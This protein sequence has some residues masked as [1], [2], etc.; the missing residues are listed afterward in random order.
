MNPE[1]AELSARCAAL[2]CSGLCLLTPAEEGAGAGARCACPE[3]WVLA[4]DGRSCAPNCTSAHF[5]CAAALKCIPFWWR[6]DTQDDCGDGSDEPA[7]CPP[8]RCEPGQF[9]CDSGRCVH[10]SH[11]CDG[12]PHCADGSDERDCDKFTCLASQWKCR[13]NAT[14]RVAAR[15]VAAA[16]RCDGRRDC[17][18]GD[19]EAACPPRTCPPHH[20]NDDI[21]TKQY[22][23]F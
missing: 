18:D 1:L 19:D 4:A 21:L 8:F 7:A 22:Y 6:C 17:H 23:L 12:T 15:C 3:H 20:C 9:Q 14:A 11:I 13:G 16:A 2:N 5:V 10:P